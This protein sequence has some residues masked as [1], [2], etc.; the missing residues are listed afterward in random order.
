VQRASYLLYPLTGEHM[1][2]YQICLLSQGI[3]T[4]KRGPGRKSSLG[5]YG[6]YGTLYR[7]N[8]IG[9]PIGGGTHSCI[10]GR[11]PYC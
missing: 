1:G 10:G 6:L 2:P 8:N 5:A 11:G 9:G 3:Q 7:Y 4:H